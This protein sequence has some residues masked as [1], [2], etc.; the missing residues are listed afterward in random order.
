MPMLEEVDISFL[1]TNMRLQELNLPSL[2]YM[3]RLGLYNNDKLKRISLPSIEF[4]GEDCFSYVDSSILDEVNINVD[5]SY[6]KLK[7]EKT[8]TKNYKITYV[9]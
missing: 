9:K 7:S 3:D 2:K 6:A 5:V 4:I 8:K 1:Q